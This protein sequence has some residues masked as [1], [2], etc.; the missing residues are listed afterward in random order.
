M[1]ELDSDGLLEDKDAL[2]GGP[3]QAAN[4]EVKIT[5]ALA[6][7]REYM[8]RDDTGVQ[9]QAAE[10]GN[11]KGVRAP[12]GCVPVLIWIDSTVQLFLS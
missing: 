2:E 7:D 12:A 10:I 5:E 11:S 3:E 1:E 4:P 9:R 6:N 8:S